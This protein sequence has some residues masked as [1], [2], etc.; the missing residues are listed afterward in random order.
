LTINKLYGILKKWKCEVKKK[1]KELNMKTEP[2]QPTPPPN[3]LSMLKA[4][5]KMLN[6]NFYYKTIDCV[7]N[8]KHI[9][10]RFAVRHKK[11]EN[12]IWI[13]KVFIYYD[14]VLEKDL[15]GRISIYSGPFDNNPVHTSFKTIEEMI[16][17][18]FKG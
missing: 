7:I 6:I 17:K 16:A 18:H 12:K 8:P 10:Y 11:D 3:R 1:Q 15:L 5:K 9:E 14:R 13:P 4:I 2:K